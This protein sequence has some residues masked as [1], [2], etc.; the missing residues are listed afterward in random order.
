MR[1]SSIK[2]KIGYCKWEGCDYHGPL[3]AGYCQT[4]YWMHRQYKKTGKIQ[5]HMTT[6]HKPTGERAFFDAIWSHREHI[7][8][9]TNLPLDIYES[10]SLYLNMF[11]HVLPKGKYGKWRL[12]DKNIVL[13]SPKEHFLFDNGTKKLREEYAKK[14]ATQGYPCRW[15]TLYDLVEKFKKDY[16]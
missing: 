10:S 14:M 4:H 16:G 2:P 15:E 5:K 12:E 13:L 11:A 1:N 9:L 6:T 7:S 3:I 8:F